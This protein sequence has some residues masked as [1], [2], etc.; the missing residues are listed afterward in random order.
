M[1]TKKTY[2]PQSNAISILHK[3]YIDQ[4]RYFY[5]ITVYEIYNNALHFISHTG[6]SEVYNEERE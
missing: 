6:P 1:M 2:T 5:S 4:S 3:V